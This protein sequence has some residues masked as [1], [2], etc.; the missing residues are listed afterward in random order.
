MHLRDLPP[1]DR[2]AWPDVAPWHYIN[3][4]QLATILGVSLQS[5][6]NWRVRATGPPF[7][8]AQTFRGPKRWYCVADVKAWLMTRH[9]QP[10]TA[11]DLITAWIDDLRGF[12]T[13]TTVEN[14]ESR[15]AMLDRIYN[16]RARGQPRRRAENRLGNRS[17]I[18]PEFPA[19]SNNYTEARTTTEAHPAN[20]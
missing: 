13:P 11:S 18:S 12:R 17:A 15:I 2:L 7:A 4:A 20:R 1:P 5:I 3:S 8:P 14:L 10:T 9:G 19:I 16:D 6:W